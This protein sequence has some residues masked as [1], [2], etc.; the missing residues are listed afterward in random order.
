MVTLDPSS[1]ERGPAIQSAS[2]EA[3]VFAL[4]PNNITVLLAPGL[5]PRC[6]LAQDWP[7]MLAGQ[8]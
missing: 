3:S 8:L 1:G 6:L 5:L 2:E 4:K 7:R